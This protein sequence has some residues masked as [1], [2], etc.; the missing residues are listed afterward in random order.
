MKIAPPHKIVIKE[1]PIHGMGVFATEKIK[2]G[3]IIEVCYLVD[4][5]L[6]I[7]KPS[8]I[9]ERYRFN[10]PQGNNLTKLVIPTG[11]GMIYNHNENPNANWR[12]N[13]D[14]ETFEFYAIR[15]IEIGEEIFTWYGGENY[16]SG[17]KS[18]RITL[19]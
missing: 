9:L 5:E 3:E 12:S 13:F 14:N 7:S 8:E 15:E 17:M 19:K 16:W 2:E 6:D 18:T 4:M 1:S 11:Y 10:W